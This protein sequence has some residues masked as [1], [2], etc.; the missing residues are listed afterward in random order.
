MAN[1]VSDLELLRLISHQHDER[2]RQQA[3]TIFYDRHKDFMWRA[4]T[5][6][7]HGNDDELKRA[8]LNNTFVNVFEYSGSFQMS[9]DSSVELAPQKVQNWLLTIS[10][11]EYKSLMVKGYYPPDPLFKEEMQEKPDI[12]ESS[13]TYSEELTHRAIEKL[14]ERDQHIVRA[15]WQYYKRGKGKQALNLPDNVLNE[16]AARY[17]ITNENIRQIIS[18][19]NRKIKAYISK[20]FDQ[21][22]K[23]LS[24]KHDEQQ[25]AQ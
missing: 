23:I 6:I 2:N 12:V 13:T 16:L 4:L 1:S 19:G 7:C 14:S 5:S 8:V 9:L 20:H 17:H 25:P 21:T 24:P 10:R 15:Y 11:R 18:R 3:F 22:N